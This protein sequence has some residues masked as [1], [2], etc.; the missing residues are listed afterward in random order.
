MKVKS[1][2]G[3]RYSLNAMVFGSIDFVMTISVMHF[4]LGCKCIPNP[5]IFGRLYE[6]L[7]LKP[8]IEY[9][10]T[11]SGS[12][13]YPGGFDCVSQTMLTSIV[14][15]HMC[16]FPPVWEILGRLLYVTSRFI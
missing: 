14:V 3:E 1:W 8:W 2:T 12:L 5:T 16:Q 7:S 9:P 10:V 13:P 6:T 11:S 15:R 4:V